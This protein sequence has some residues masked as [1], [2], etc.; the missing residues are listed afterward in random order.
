MLSTRLLILYHRVGDG[1]QVKV[2]VS[3]L[4]TQ[5]T[6]V[7]W[8]KESYKWAL[9]ETIRASKHGESPTHERIE[10]L[11][12]KESKKV[13]ITI[14]HFFEEKTQARQQPSKKPRWGREVVDEQC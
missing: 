4:K 3:S 6:I 7:G 11:Q 10:M 12:D 8:D 14:D 1:K 2:S 5:V 13:Q 9:G